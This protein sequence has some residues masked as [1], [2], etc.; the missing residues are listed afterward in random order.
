MKRPHNNSKIKLF[1]FA[2]IILRVKKQ[3]ENVSKTCFYDD[4]GTDLSL[5]FE[6]HYEYGDFG[7]GWE[8]WRC[9]G[10]M[11]GK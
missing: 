9:D 8:T 3:D 1:V 2:R 5:F 6:K 10:R 4:F 7:D 11:V